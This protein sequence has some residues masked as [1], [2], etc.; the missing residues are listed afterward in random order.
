MNW[1]AGNTKT[2]SLLKGRKIRKLAC[3]AFPVLEAS[4][5]DVSADDIDGL[6]ASVSWARGQKGCKAKKDMS[7]RRSCEDS[8]NEI[9]Q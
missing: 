9:W 5:D 8:L 6:I 4:W 1:A 7:L 3:T 2:G